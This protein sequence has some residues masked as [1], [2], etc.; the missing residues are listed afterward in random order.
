MPKRDLLRSI[1]CC[2][3]ANIEDRN[4]F[5]DVGNTTTL[6]QKD[7]RVTPLN[8]R[9]WP[10]IDVI[11]FEC[12]MIA[13]LVEDLSYMRYCNKAWRPKLTVG[14][15]RVWIARGPQQHVAMSNGD[16]KK[17]DVC[18]ENRS[19]FQKERWS[20][21]TTSECLKIFYCEISMICIN[22]KPWLFLSSKEM[23]AFLVAAIA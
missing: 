13:Y 6:V 3:L 12:R 9:L 4:L 2:A 8:T 1:Y 19:L 10:W 23:D 14:W 15:D 20:W 17:G 5:S 7:H 16:M 21:C 18:M 22:N 11:Q